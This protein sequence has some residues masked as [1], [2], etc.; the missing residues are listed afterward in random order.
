MTDEPQT[1]T[2][3]LLEVGDADAARVRRAAFTRLLATAAPITAAMLATEVDL[4]DEQVE[5]ALRRLAAAGAISRD[6]SG[7]VVAAGGLAVTRAWH[8]LLLDGRQYWTWCAFDGIG[9]PAAL[10]LD[11]VLDTRC[12]TCGAG[13]RITIT[14]GSLPA[15][16]PVVGV[17]PRRTVRQRPG[18]L[19]PRGQPVLHRGPPGHLAPDGRRPTR[20][21]RDP[22]RARR[23]RTAGVGRPHLTPGQPDAAV[24]N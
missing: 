19:L 6:E 16:I 7:E 2:A 24:G 13:L 10:E 12:P 11:A 14:A 8:R 3:G 23:D 21:R 9:I 17:A 20:H 18:R 15:G 1:P 22:A 4:T 5:A